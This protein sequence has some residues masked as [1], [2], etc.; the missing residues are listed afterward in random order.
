MLELLQ[1]FHTK[2]GSIIARD[3][4]DNW[5]QPAEKFVKVFPY[6][7]QKA[8]KA[9]AAQESAPAQKVNGDVRPEGKTVADIEDTVPDPLTVKKREEIIDKMR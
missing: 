5:P 1:Q 4:L 3:L 2:T 6:E 8:L 7:Y 9:M